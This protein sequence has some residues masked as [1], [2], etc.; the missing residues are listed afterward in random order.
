MEWIIS[1]DMHFSTRIDS[2]RRVNLIG[3]I[4]SRRIR[5]SSRLQTTR[6]LIEFPVP[7]YGGLSIL[8][9]IDTP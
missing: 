8:R 2:E 9:I 7:D 4:Y 1:R 5:D 6:G 3:R